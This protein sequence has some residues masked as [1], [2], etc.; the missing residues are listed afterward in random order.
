MKKIFLLFI[1]TL[2]PS[3]LDSQLIRATK[4]MGNYQNADVYVDTSG[5]SHNLFNLLLTNKNL[6]SKRGLIIKFEKEAITLPKAPKDSVIELT[7]NSIDSSFKKLRNGFEK[8]ENIFSYYK[9]LKIYPDQKKGEGSQ[10]FELIFN[11][12]VNVDS[13]INHLHTINLKLLKN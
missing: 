7:W 9:M 3:T 10:K 12:L 8:L 2:I 5:I 4:E 13:V 6:Y 11:R 1:F